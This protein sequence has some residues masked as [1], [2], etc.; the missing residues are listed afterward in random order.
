MQTPYNL[1]QSEVSKSVLPM[2]LEDSSKRGI[3]LSL[4]RVNRFLLSR[5]LNDCLNLDPEN[6]S[7]VV[8]L[9]QELEVGYSV[10]IS[11]QSLCV[12]YMLYLS[13][14]FCVSQILLSVLDV[15]PMSL[16][17][18]LAAIAS[19]KKFL[20]LV[21]WLTTNLSACE[22]TFFEVNDNFGAFIH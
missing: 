18:K 22:E 19:T 20:D 15:V 21:E 14:K 17:I 9:F 3:I 7:R 11:S 8:D 2:L 16:G 12:G 1:L 6:L 5:T 13:F 10:L 4:W